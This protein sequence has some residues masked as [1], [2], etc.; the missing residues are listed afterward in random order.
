[1]LV[2]FVYERIDLDELSSIKD[3]K[4]F[5]DDFYVDSFMNNSPWSAMAFINGEWN[6]VTPIDKK[7]FNELMKIKNQ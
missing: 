3:I 5:W 2:K 6:D 1:M 7:L 4:K